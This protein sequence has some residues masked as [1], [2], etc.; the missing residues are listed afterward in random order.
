MRNNEEQKTNVIYRYKEG[1]SNAVR[2]KVGMAFF[3]NYL[4]Q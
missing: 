2:T 3:F 4:D 1:Y